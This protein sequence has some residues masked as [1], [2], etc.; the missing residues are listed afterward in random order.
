LKNLARELKKEIP[1]AAVIGSVPRPNQAFWTLSAL[2][3]GWLWGHEAVEPFKV[4]LRRRRYDWAWNATALSAA[5]SHL[6]DLLPLNTPFFGLLPEAEPS[7]L[8]STLSAA[9]TAGFDLQS[10]ALRTEHDPIQLVWRRGEHLKREM[11]EPDVEEVRSA[12]SEHLAERGEPASYLHIHATGL[13]SLIESHSLTKK[14][15]EF[16]ETLRIVQALIQSALEE[17]SRFTH[18]STG[19]SVDSGMWGSSRVEGYRES[20]ADRVEVAVVTFLQKNPSSIYLEVEDDIYPRFPGLLTPSK[21]MIYAVL[22]SYAVRENGAWMLR[23]EDMASMRRSE[24]NKVGSMIEALGSRLGYSTTRQDRLYLWQENGQSIY[25]FYVLASALVGR[26]LSE[27]TFLQERAILV[28][29]GGR[30]SLAAYK[31]QR[32]PSLAARLKDVRVV[33]YRL[34]RTLLEVPV[35]T[36][37]S[38]GKQIASDPLEKSKLQMILF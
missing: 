6:F 10:M 38:F 9:T 28:L 30:A 8:T 37:E 22:S 31:T 27:I 4:A 36:R 19:E 14:E 2:W 5:F 25:A 35:L 26:A 17:D 21:G 1:I 3:A 34:L 33:K 29:P 20:L 16:D 11:N 24:L 15:Q 32:D 23:A 13:V 18:Y 12:I 7:F